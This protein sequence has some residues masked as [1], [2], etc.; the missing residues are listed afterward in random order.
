MDHNFAGELG[1]QVGEFIDIKSLEPSPLPIFP[2]RH[3]GT[4]GVGFMA[5]LVGGAIRA[6]VLRAY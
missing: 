2:P 4:V 1:N 6:H 5:C 3:T